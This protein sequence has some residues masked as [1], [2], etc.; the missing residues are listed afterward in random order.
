MSA[1][2][3]WHQDRFAGFV[4]TAMSY[5]PPRTEPFVLEEVW[6]MMRQRVGSDIYGYWEVFNG[7]DGHVLCEKNVSLGLR[8]ICMSTS[9]TRGSCIGKR[10]GALSDG[11]IE[12]DIHFHVSWHSRS[13]ASSSSPTRPPQKSGE[14]TSQKRGERRRGSRATADRGT[15]PGF[16]KRSVCPL[17]LVSAYRVFRLMLSV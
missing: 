5:L 15:G 7:P 4:W 16:P 8:A 14:M 2:A 9:W 3:H 17:S 10:L 6:Q 13:T 12:F 1:L 11:F